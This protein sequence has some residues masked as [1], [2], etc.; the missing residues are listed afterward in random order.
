V[1]TLTGAR[2]VLMDRVVHPGWIALRDG[3]IEE[4]GE[5]APPPGS[6]AVRDVA[7]AYVT[8]GYV[9][10][11]MH[12][13]GGHSVLTSRAD[14]AAAVAFHAARGSTSTLVSAVTAPLEHMREVAGW[15]ADLTTAPAGARVLG[16][17]LEGPFLA[18][19][20][21][22]AQDPACLLQPDL[23]ALEELLAA[24]RGTVRTM[25]LAPELPGAGAL[26]ERLV[27]AGVVPAVGHTGATYEQTAAALAAGARLLTHAFNGMPGIHHRAPG[28]VAAAIDH[29][30]A[31]CE[32][33]NDGE[34]V[35]PPA[36]RL[37]FRAM[38]GRVALVTDA[39]SAAGAADGPYQL[40]GQRV[41]VRAGVARLA[42]APEKTAGTLAGSTLTMDAAV[43]RAVNQLGLSIEDAVAA[44]SFVPARVLGLRAGRL[45]PGYPADILILDDDL[46]VREVLT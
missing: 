37:L 13:G 35:H 23:A 34:H 42:G 12:G 16:S 17:H 5:G 27:A 43:R 38:P 25:T 18:A 39:I 26:I 29:A 20:H 45:L 19:A 11:H 10:L 4:V 3:A 32:L 1:T 15:A 30:A 33:I 24:G 2:L 46:R 8:P 14:M 36:A 44:A 40:G 21:R 28:P 31:V 6:L 22:G 9:D 41:L 7:G